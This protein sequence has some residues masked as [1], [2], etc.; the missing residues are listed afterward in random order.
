MLEYI[1]KELQLVCYFCYL[2][3]LFFFDDEKK[4]MRD[5]KGYFKKKEF[6]KCF[7]LKGEIVCKEF[8]EK[9]KCY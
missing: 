7:I 3:E 6:L 2:C 4:D 8:L 9:F 5:G 1:Y